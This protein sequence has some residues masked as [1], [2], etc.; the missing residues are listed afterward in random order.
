VAGTGRIVV[1]RPNTSIR[2]RMRRYKIAVDGRVVG[3]I[4]AGGE[5][6]VDVPVGPHTVQ[7]KLDWGRSPAVTV[8]VSEGSNV[9]LIIRPGRPYL[10][11]TV[12]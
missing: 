9:H 4:A 5:L 8:E 7:G 3:K 11:L 2:G 6:T 10:S 12:M 1:E